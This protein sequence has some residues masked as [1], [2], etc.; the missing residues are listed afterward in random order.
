ME[1]ISEDAIA[2]GLA[3]DEKPLREGGTGATA[4]A[5]AVA[6]YLGFAVDKAADRNAALC[7]LGITAQNM[8]AQHLRPTSAS[9][10]VGFCGSKSILRTPAGNFDRCACMASLQGIAD[11]SPASR[12]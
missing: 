5:E 12:G 1:R 10:G 2:A 3:D 11:A 4:Y 8:I 6:V 7:R 9:D